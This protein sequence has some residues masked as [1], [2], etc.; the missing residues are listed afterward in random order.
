MKHLKQDLKSIF[1][2]K[3]IADLAADKITSLK[4]TFTGV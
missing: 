1:M 3:D 4:Q 2:V